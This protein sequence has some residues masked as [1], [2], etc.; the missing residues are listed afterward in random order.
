MAQLNFFKFAGWPVTTTGSCLSLNRDLD[1]VGAG[2]GSHIQASRSDKL[3]LLARVSPEDSENGSHIGIVNGLL[4]SLEQP[5]DMTAAQAGFTS[6]IRLLEPVSFRQA[7]QRSAEIAHKFFCSAC[8]IL[9][10]FRFNA[11]TL[12]G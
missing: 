12:A 3:R 1:Q 9:W 4:I 7:V 6:K 5:R 11:I 10:E 8:P 2:T